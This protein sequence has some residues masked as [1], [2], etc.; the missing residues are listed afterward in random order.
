M[1]MS[2]IEPD[3]ADPADELSGYQPGRPGGRA[4]DEMPGPDRSRR[5]S[6]RLQRAGA[7]LLAA[8]CGAGALWYVP[9][10]MAADSR[11]L[12]GAVSSNGLTYLNFA[13]PGQVAAIAVQVGQHVRRG[14]LLAT[15][16]APVAAAVVAADGAAIKAARSQLAAITAGGVPAA[17]AGAQAHL[18]ASRAQLGIDRAKVSQTRIVAPADGTVVA[19][20]GQPGEFASDAGIRGYPAAG[21]PAAASRQ[22]LFSLLPEGPQASIQAGGTAAS[23]LA[24]PVVELQTSKSWQVSVLVP[25]NL[26]AAVRPGRPVTVS[27]PAAGLSGIP[28]RVRELLSTPAVTADGTAYLAVITVLRQ[29]RAA[30]D[31]MSANVQLGS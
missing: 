25:E 21:Q 24:L 5:R 9:R 16:S 14:E 8:A 31:G 6:G 23:A 2:L 18:A 29:S 1:D 28:G 11:S 4:L 30:A 17:I 27:V 3:Y 10:I 15:E 19:V 20:N 26:V 12:A 7:L 13:A 22:P